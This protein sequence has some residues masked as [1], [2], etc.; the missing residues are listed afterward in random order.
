M[1]HNMEEITSALESWVDPWYLAYLSICCV[2]GFAAL[3]Y[4]STVEA[5]PCG[6]IQLESFSETIPAQER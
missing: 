3:V 4:I 5:V 6:E 2:L 1:E